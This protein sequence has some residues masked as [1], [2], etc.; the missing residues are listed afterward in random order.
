[1]N[2]TSLT[3]L[4]MRLPPGWRLSHRRQ[5]GRWELH[6]AGQLLG[7]APNALKIVVLANHLIAERRA[8]FNLQSSCTPAQQ[9]P[10]ADNANR[11]V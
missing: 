7:S 9:A 2:A 10:T 6:A 1:V 3:E 4:R 5:R 11:Y 8:A